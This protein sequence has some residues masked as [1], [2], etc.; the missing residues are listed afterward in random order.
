M[1]LRR[2]FDFAEFAQRLDDHF[3]HLVTL[4]DVGHFTSAEQDAH[5]HFI[6]VLKEL[7]RAANFGAD[8]LFT[9]LGT[10]ADLLGLGV[11]VPG[12]S[13]LVLVDLPSSTAQKPK[14]SSFFGGSVGLRFLCGWRWN[15][16]SCRLKS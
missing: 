2:S 12:V 8:I 4:F 10:K 13:F 16:D 3:H 11:R 14:V 15:G 7:L 1:L 5:L 6:L 9:S